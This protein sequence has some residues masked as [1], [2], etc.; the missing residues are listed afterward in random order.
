MDMT[1]MAIQIQRRYEAFGEREALLF[2]V[3]GIPITVLLA[4]GLSTWYKPSPFYE[5]HCCVPFLL[6]PCLSWPTLLSEKKPPMSSRLDLL[7]VNHRHM[8]MPLGGPYIAPGASHPASSSLDDI[9]S[10][11]A[12]SPT[13]F[14]GLHTHFED[15][16]LPP[17][18]S[19][20]SPT[21]NTSGTTPGAIDRAYNYLARQYNSARND[22]RIE[23]REHNLLK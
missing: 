9:S 4:G 22:L 6:F 11:M 15:S 5:C 18:G 2:V 7:Q 13:S 8:A 16:V 23:K 21:S 12:S 19:L 20:S 14:S 3:C 10:S 17:C 1:L